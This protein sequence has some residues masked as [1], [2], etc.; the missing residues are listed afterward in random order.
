MRCFKDENVINVTGE[1]DPIGASEIIETEL[2]LSDMQQ[3]E[4]A[5]DKVKKIG[6]V[7]R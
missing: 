6:Q 3:C 1:L 7:W 5:L 4:K 2:L